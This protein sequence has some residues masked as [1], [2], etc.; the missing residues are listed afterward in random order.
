MNKIEYVWLSNVD[1]SNQ[2]KFKL[3]N[4]FEGIDNLY[5][6]SLDELIDFGIK[7]EMLFKISDKKTKEK[8]LRDYE[9]MVRNS[10]YLISFEDIEYPKKFNYVKDKPVSIYI[11]GNRNIL[12]N[13]AIGIVGSRVALKESM[14][15]ARLVSNFF[16]NKGVHI[17][18]GLAKGIDK[19]AHLGALDSNSIG[20]TIGVLA[21]GLDKKSF[22][23]FE[24]LKVYERII[25]E[26]GAVISEYPIGIEPKP[27]FF[28]YRN[29]II[30]ALSEKIFVIQA[31]NLK[32]GSMI[33]V[34]YALEQGK[35]VYVYKS[36]N[37]EN[38]YFE[39]NRLL[40]NDGAKIFNIS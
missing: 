16:V 14:E 19:S 25:K 9:Y 15:I 30:S 40:I 11:K 28:P 38:K 36:R 5:N 6:C 23:P 3:I 34:D 22:Y 35:D 18:S 39:G 33:T 17:V 8:S 20:K 26:G 37:I 21:C 29:R 32:S 10:I 12:D 27:Y 13:N 7:D 31:S 1:I 2:N 24:N 4:K